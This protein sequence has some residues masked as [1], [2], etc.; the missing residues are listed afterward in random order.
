MGVYLAYRYERSPWPEVF[1]GG[2]LYGVTLTDP[3]G[4]EWVGRGDTLDSAWHAAVDRARFFGR[5]KVTDP[6]PWP[7]PFS[8]T[9]VL[10]RGLHRFLST[11]WRLKGLTIRGVFG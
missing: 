10:V 4:T 2:F 3:T 11:A 1:C 5:L 6:C 9:D 7:E 8:A